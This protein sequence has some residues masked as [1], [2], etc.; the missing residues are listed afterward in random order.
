LCWGKNIILSN[1]PN[2]YFLTIGHAEGYTPLNAFD[3]ALHDAKIGNTN[4][5]KISSIIPPNC[6]EIDI[7]EKIP[8][9]A[10]VPIA[11]A[12]ICSN[13]H[14]E[15]I[16]SAIATAIPDNSEK[17]G[18]IMEYSARGHKEEVE[19]IV[20]QM[21]EEGMRLREET[22]FQVKSVSVQHKV[23]R[24]GATFAGVVLWYE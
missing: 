20:L 5:V 10:F 7:P 8:Y 16:A 17:P 14:G 9:G 19:D 23:D 18:L 22:E 1:L 11:Y 2:V 4:L 15:M 21:V 6:R 3:A 12:N 24:V 13:L